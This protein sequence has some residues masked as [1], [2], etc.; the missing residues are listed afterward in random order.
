MGLL[1]GNKISVA[2]L[3]SKKSISI[4]KLTFPSTVAAIGIVS[5][6]LF[7]AFQTSVPS[8]SPNFK[9]HSLQI[10]TIKFS[11]PSLEE[12]NFLSYSYL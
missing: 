5:K 4:Q 3:I 7:A 2:H 8:F 1:H 12:I 6:A 11:T 9:Q 10:S